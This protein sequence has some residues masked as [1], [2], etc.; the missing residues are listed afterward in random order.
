MPKDSKLP[1]VEI[2]KWNFSNEKK[3]KMAHEIVE[4]WEEEGPTSYT[5]LEEKYGAASDSHYG[6]VMD[7]HLGPKD[8]DITV[9]EIRA[10]YG[11][12]SD[13]LEL[14]KQGEIET[15]TQEL[16]DRELDDM[17]EYYAKGR[18]DGVVRGYDMG[19]DQALEIAEKV[20]VENVPRKNEE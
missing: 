12:V 3:E 14:R 13:Y 6:N 7:E 17:Q 4:T 5:E 11:S 18:D 16:T 1:A 8:H 2:K 10:Q 19:W 15:D 9:E 20:G